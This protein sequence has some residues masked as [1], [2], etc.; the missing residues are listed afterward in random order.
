[1]G[2][3]EGGDL[4]GEGCLRAGVEKACSGTHSKKVSAMGQ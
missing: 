2:G 3:C 4:G 1:M